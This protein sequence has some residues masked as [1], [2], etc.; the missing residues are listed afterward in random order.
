L[1]VNI[2]VVLGSVGLHAELQRRLANEKTAHGEAIT[3]ILLDK[4]EGVA[5]RDKDFMRFIR[6]AAIKEYFFG[7]SKR[8]LSP[9]TQSV[10]FD[11]V[12]IFKAPD[13][14]APDI[15][16][17]KYGWLIFSQKQTFTTTSKPSS[18]RRSQ[19]RCRIGLSQS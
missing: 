7:D 12:A 5:D 15:L 3:V 14:N 4:S 8:T 18:P 1:A 13:G 19:R 9:F 16:C 11:D 6:E 17:L 2:V 10:S